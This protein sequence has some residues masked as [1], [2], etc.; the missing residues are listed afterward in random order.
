[1]SYILYAAL[2][3]L[4]LVLCI[5]ASV[6]AQ[7]I[8]LPLDVNRHELRNGLQILTLENHTLPIISYYTFF[9][10]GSRHES[11]GQTGISHLLVHM[12]FNGAR[13]YRPKEFDQML[14]SGGG[15]A[16]A[17]TTEDMTVYYEHFPD[18][19][20]ELIVDMESDRMAHLA[21]TEQSLTSE[22]AIVKEERRIQIDNS[23]SGQVFELLHA[24]A[25]TAH[26]YRWPV[27]GWMSNL[28]AITL[29]DCKAYFRTHYSPNQ[30]MIVLVGDFDTGSCSSYAGFTNAYSREEGVKGSE[31]RSAKQYLSGIFPLSIEGPRALA[32]QWAG[33]ELFGLPKNYI[34]IYRDQVKGVSEDEISRVIQDHIPGEIWLAV[35]LG[36]ADDII[37]RIERLGPIERHDF[38]TLDRKASP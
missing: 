34:E 20:L 22:R 24:L 16:N 1:M 28:D 32:N 15:F 7:P 19:Q 17:Y 11:I 8:F 3:G 6:S 13:R 5:A 33:I 29:G 30:A 25:Y 9:R 10:V 21:L 14:E 26:P 23:V 38:R 27:L 35:V 4:F 12:M 36:K 18:D 37:P 31:I 2:T